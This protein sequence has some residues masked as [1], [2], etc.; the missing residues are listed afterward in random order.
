MGLL[1]AGCTE[2]QHVSHY[3]DFASV[4]LSFRH[5][6]SKAEQDILGGRRNS[7]S[8]TLVPVRHLINFLLSLFV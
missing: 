2:V 7:H 1:Y 5:T 3:L 8:G 6:V 4:V